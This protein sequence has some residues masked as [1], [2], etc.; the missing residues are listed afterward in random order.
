MAMFALADQ[1]GDNTNQVTSSAKATVDFTGG[2]VDML[3]DRFYMS[4][5]RVL[6]GQAQALSTLTVSRGTIDANEMILGY[7]EHPGQTNTQTYCQGTLNVTN[8]ATV[9]INGNLILGY[10]TE[11]NI[12]TTAGFVTDTNLNFGHLNIGPGGTVMASNIMVGGPQEKFSV[13]TISVANGGTLIVSNTLADP[14]KALDTLTI[15]GGSTNVLHVDCNNTTTPLEYVAQLTMSGTDF[16]KIGAVQNVA[17]V[18]VP[19]IFYT[20]GSA[21]F[22][23][24]AIMPPPPLGVAAL[25]GVL[26]KDEVA[27]PHVL[28]LDILTNAPKN[29]AWRGTGVSANWNSSSK[30]WA[31]LNNGGVLTNFVNGDNVVFD[32]TAGLAA[33]V[34]ITDV[35]M[36]PGSVT[37]TNSTY[38]YVFSAGGGTLEGTALW[39]KW[40]SNPLQIDAPTTVSVL[41]NQGSLIGSG[42]VGAVTIAAGSTISYSGNIVGGI[43][44]A[45]TGVVA[46]SVTGNVSLNGG[47]GTLTNMGTITGL[48][49]LGTNTLFVNGNSINFVGLGTCNIASNALFINDKNITGDGFAVNGTFKDNGTGIIGLRETIDFNAGSLFIPG[50]DSIG[51]TS[52]RPDGD[53]SHT[54]AARVTF[55]NGSTVIFKV[56]PNTVSATEVLSGKQAFG[57]NPSGQT[58]GQ[59]GC[60]LIITNVSGVPYTNGQ[61]YTLCQY[62]FTGDILPTG[63]ATNAYPIIS[64]N[65]PVPP[66]TG[67]AWD[68]SQITKTGK[69]GI[70]GI[71]TTPVTLGKSFTIGTNAVLVG[72]NVIVTNTLVTHLT[73]PSDHTGYAVWQQS[74]PDTIGLSTNWSPIFYSFTNNEFYITNIT[75]TMPDTMFF[76]LQYPPFPKQAQ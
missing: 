52:F 59:F 41:V 9:K 58:P 22:A 75:T 26:R 13:N 71:S 23:G 19:L 39:N 45:G 51:T 14:L 50:G 30:N 67:L 66:A 69:L 53:T 18:E 62:Y 47:T 49:S 12:G 54:N 1:G 27:V 68:I 32:D 56:D 3:V 63:I 61:V 25:N 46:G 34:V 48:P 64:P 28:Y 15:T 42:S 55:H 36:I 24:Q 7:Q 70:F 38:N 57:D 5:D 21:T 44:C 20:N 74:N 11:T 4:R 31:D 37:M 8:L 40:G 33:T 65:V 16:I 73:W 6:M 43:G 2:T 76:R 35:G 72:T 10:V 17:A 29:L 60:T